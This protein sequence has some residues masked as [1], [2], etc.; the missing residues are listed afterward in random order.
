ME[1]LSL[2]E[3]HEQPWCPDFIRN[4][5]TGII[6]FISNSLP[7][8]TPIVAELKAA[9]EKTQDTHILDMAAGSGGPWVGLSKQLKASG[10]PLKSVMLSDHYPNPD[11]AER[12]RDR[13]A[14]ELSYKP[15]SVD[16]RDVPAEVPGFR[17]MFAAFHHFDREDAKKIL[18]DAVNE[19]RGIGI[20]E[21]TERGLLAMLFIGLTSII[22][23]LV[24]VPFV[25]PFKALYV[26]F[27]Y[28]LPILPLVLL[29]DGIVSCLRTYSVAEMER[30]VNELDA[31]D[32]E[33]HIGRRQQ[34]PLPV[35][36]MIGTPR[37]QDTDEVA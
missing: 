34:G 36:Y 1:R 28:L 20:F 30:M 19:R 24:A 6:Q 27:T 13:V 7:A 17:T 16:A 2:F 25:R 8:Y 32:Y 11:A 15:E 29:F 3:I 22:W 37:T 12:L 21:I 4:G 9:L 26:P 18:Q 31:P 10:A 23:A 33:W 5:T 35:L 14:L